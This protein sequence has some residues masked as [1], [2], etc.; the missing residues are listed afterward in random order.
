MTRVVFY[1]GVQPG[2]SLVGGTVPGPHASK[3]TITVMVVL[4]QLMVAKDRIVHPA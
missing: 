2:P 4:W 1:S 3:G